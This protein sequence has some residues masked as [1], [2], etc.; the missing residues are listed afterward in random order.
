MDGRAVIDLAAGKVLEK[1][2]NKSV[3]G[4]R[5]ERLNSYEKRFHDVQASARLCARSY[6]ARE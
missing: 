6:L 4:Q 2:V 3:A 5:Q 1:I